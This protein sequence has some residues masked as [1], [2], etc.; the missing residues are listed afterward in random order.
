MHHGTVLNTNCSPLRVHLTHRRV[1]GADS[2]GV[3]ASRF[4]KAGGEFPPHMAHQHIN[5][6]EGYALQQVLH[7]F[8]DDRPTRL[9]GSTLVSDVDSKVLH[10]AFKRG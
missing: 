9:A 3:L 1:D 7:L 4:F 6:Q 2:L 10:D 8:A 5:V